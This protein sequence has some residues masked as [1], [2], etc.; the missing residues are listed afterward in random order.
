[1][2]VLHG[3]PTALLRLAMLVLA[4]SAAFVLALAP[5]ARVEANGV[6]TSVALK[7]IDLSNWG[8]QDATG[9][10][11][12]LLAEGVVKVTAEGLPAL[13]TQRYQAWLVSSQS[14]DA[15]SAGRFNAD[16]AGKVDFR[17]SLPPIANFGFDLFII[18]VEP[19]PDDAPQP[20]VKR[21]I[22]GY[23]SLVGQ[24]AA[25]GSREGGAPGQLPNT[26]DAGFRG[27]LLRAGGLLGAMAI[28]VLIGMQL[29]RRQA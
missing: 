7:Y 26:G 9:K 2:T 23:F 8:P 11:D 22:G 13:T 29:N 5:V 16:A 20:A 12:L 28:A 24:R 27:D 3:R 18:T 10:A 15:I 25:D 19:E 17:G 14:G 4:A 1:M 21:T 6:P